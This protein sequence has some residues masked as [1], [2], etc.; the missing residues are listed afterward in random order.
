VCQ[1]FSVNWWKNKHF[2]HHAVPNIHKADPDI[3]TMPYLAWSEQALEFFNDMDEK[4]VAKFLV[5]HQPIL[6]FPL[7]SF[8]RLSWA[9]SSI[10]FK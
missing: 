3:D 10:F 7:L 1:G 9:M 6:Y 8:A 2:V 4:T 5:S